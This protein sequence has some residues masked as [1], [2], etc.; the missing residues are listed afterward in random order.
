MKPEPELTAPTRSRNAK[1][2]GPIIGVAAVLAGGISIA[3]AS[4]GKDKVKTAPSA[5][6]TTVAST[7]PT[8]ATS[9]VGSSAP[10]ATTAPT[11]AIAYPL[12]FEQAKKTGLSDKVN[13]GKRCDTA[14]GTLAV[15]DYFAQPC[16]APFT[17]DNGGA[18]AQGVTKDEITIVYYIGQEADPIISY[19]TDAIKNTDTNAGRAKT[20]EGIVKYY[21]TFFELYG[22]KV[23]LISYEGTGGA[24]D[25]LAARADAQVVA[26]KYK[27]FVVF[28]GPALTSG[29]ADELAARKVMCIG[30]TPAQPTDFYV[31]RDPYV[32]ALDAS[33]E[34][35]QTHAVEFLKKQIIG[36][37]AT[38]AGEKLASTPRKFGLIYL[39]SSKASKD[40]ADAY[41]KAM[42]DAGAPFADVV[43]YALDPATIQ[44]SASQAISKMKS[45]G[46]TTIVFSGDPVA[47]RDF[48]KEATA[49]EYFPEWFV[50][51]ATLV[52]TNAFARTY[53]QQ[54]WA[55]AFGVTTLAARTNPTTFGYNAIYKWFSGAPAPAAD[56]I[57]VIQPSPALFFAVAQGVGPNLTPQTFK[58]TLF[59][60]LGTKP[61]VSQP[62]LSWGDKLWPTPDYEGIDDATVIWWD[63]KASGPDEIR[64]QGTGMYQFVDG[65]KRYLAGQWPTVDKL[66]DPDGAV[67]IYDT[68]PPG[69]APPSYPSLTP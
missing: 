40:L 16:F 36:K 32:W 58:T 45:A 52:D 44:A 42:A 57:G 48:S 4:G 51:A 30:C 41:A 13:W 46:V 19:I 17:G 35:K 14:K 67:A 8:P 10:T 65:G 38:H 23:K 47:P 18:T 54:Q 24:L 56:S 43:A 12:T 28:G 60:G 22:R 15:P 55:H 27:P 6:S 69:E 29:F 31:A 2:L 33:A 49:Q 1:R 37:N 9:A 50:S 25:E 3:V 5:A 62:F 59:A 34:Q 64:K 26:E 68:P 53:D 11:A 7:L 21:E 39:Q 20:M 61:A 66:F 63:P